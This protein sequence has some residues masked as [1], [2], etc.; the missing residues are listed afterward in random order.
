MSEFS[1]RKINPAESPALSPSASPIASPGIIGNSIHGGL[2]VG[3]K[4]LLVGNCKDARISS[5]RLNLKL[6]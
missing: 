5:D 6:N 2:Q 1:L 4:N 3:P